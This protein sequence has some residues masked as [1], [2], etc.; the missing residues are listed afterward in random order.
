LSTTPRLGVVI[1]LRFVISGAVKGVATPLPNPAVPFYSGIKTTFHTLKVYALSPALRRNGEWRTR[2]PNFKTRVADL[3][4]RAVNPPVRFVA[5]SP[6]RT[7]PAARQWTSVAPASPAQQ[8]GAK[9]RIIY[10]HYA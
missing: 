5:A 9:S 4:A 8:R 3:A 7:E 2:V 1:V 10:K 6:H